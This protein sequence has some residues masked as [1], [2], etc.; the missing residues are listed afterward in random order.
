MYIV[1]KGKLIP[2][3]QNNTTVHLCVLTQGLQCKVAGLSE[4]YGPTLPLV[5]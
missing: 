1:E 3:T 4:F 2:L 5:K